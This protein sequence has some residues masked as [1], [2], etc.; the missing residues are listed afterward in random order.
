MESYTQLKQRHTQEFN[1]FQYI[2]FAFSN[3]QLAEGLKKLNATTK[4]IYSIGAGGFVLKAHNQELRDMIDRHSAELEA[5]KKDRKFLLESL[6]YE[7]RNHEYSITYD[8]TDA[9]DALGLE[10]ADIPADI[11][12][13]AKILALGQSEP[14]LS[15]VQA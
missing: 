1:D 3:D 12:N 15:E 11:L 10:L 4:D 13:K 8:E 6:V 7:L 2:F 5:N 9:L 14:E